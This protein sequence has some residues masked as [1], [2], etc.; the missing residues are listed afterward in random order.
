MSFL[1][2]TAQIGFYLPYNLFLYGSIHNYPSLL[3][4]ILIFVEKLNV[5]ASYTKDLIKG[6]S[7]TSNIHSK[8]AIISQ[9]FKVIILIAVIVLFLIYHKFNDSNMF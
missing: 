6:E 5:L 9:S 4:F 8:Y 2:T 3:I 1:I 7:S